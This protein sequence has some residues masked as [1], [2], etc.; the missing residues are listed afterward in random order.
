MPHSEAVA[1]KWKLGILAAIVVFGALIIAMAFVQRDLAW[2]WAL[3][4]LLYIPAI[5]I[6]AAVLKYFVILAK[7]AFR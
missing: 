5:L 1:R 4:L 6:A 7:R 2:A 3:L